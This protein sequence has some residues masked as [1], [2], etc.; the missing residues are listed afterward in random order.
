MSIQTD[1][2]LRVQ[3]IMRIYGI[4]RSTVYAKAK[5][6]LIPLPASIPNMKFRWLRSDIEADLAAKIASA[7]NPYGGSHAS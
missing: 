5:E 2:L 1:E 7:K 4:A 3:D 6:G